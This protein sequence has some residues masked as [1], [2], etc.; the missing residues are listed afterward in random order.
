MASH[1]VEELMKN[2]DFELFQREFKRWQ[3]KFGLTGYK[4]YFKYGLLE[5]SFADIR[6]NQ[7][8][9]VATVTL[10]NELPDK[11]RPHRD[12]RCSAKHEALHLLISRLELAGHYRYSSE[13]E[14][15]EA[16][17]ELVHKLEDLIL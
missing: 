14:I 11:E 8:D 12:V 6:V 4:V 2:R 13:N 5:K 16:A 1:S 17:E 7:G 3:D 15:Y 9:M 10:N